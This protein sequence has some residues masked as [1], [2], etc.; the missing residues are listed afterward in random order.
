MV[1]WSNRR[2]SIEKMA[3]M[4]TKP[5]SLNRKKLKFRRNSYLIVATKGKH[6]FIFGFRSTGM[7][8]LAHESHEP[9]Y[10][11]QRQEATHSVTV[12]PLSINIGK[13]DFF[14]I[15]TISSN[16]SHIFILKSI[17]SKQV[18]M[19]IVYH[20]FL[21]LANNIELFIRF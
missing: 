10:D 18:K 7:L 15:F 17:A 19:D 8:K 1:V 6:S 14:F 9:T 2:V 21:S 12:T 4:I 3:S 13:P 16:L 5:G 11:T 20:Q